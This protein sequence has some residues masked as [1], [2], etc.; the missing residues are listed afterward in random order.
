[1]RKRVSLTQQ[2]MGLCFCDIFAIWKFSIKMALELSSHPPMP[3][4]Y[5]NGGTRENSS[6]PVNVSDSAPSS[7][8]GSSAFTVVTPK[9]RDRKFILHKIVSCPRFAS[10][11][12]LDVLRHFSSWQMCV[13]ILFN[14]HQEHF[15]IIAIYFLLRLYQTQIF[16]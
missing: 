3:L 1:M 11:A 9:G 16:I 6:S 15:L 7:P 4:D 13:V 5:S 8:P 14:C 2:M 10:G 12:D